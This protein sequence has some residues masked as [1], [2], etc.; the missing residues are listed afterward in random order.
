MAVSY[1]TYVP[2]VGDSGPII[3]ADVATPMQ[4]VVKGS[5]VSVR[6]PQ[7]AVAVFPLSESPPSR[8][9]ATSMHRHTGR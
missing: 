4:T 3:Q 5:V 8:R 1:P 7:Q 6:E 9:A 2:R